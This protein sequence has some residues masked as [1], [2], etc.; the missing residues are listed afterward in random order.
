MKH[1]LKQQLVQKKEMFYAGITP[2]LVHMMHVQQ[3]QLVPLIKFYVQM[4][5]VKKVD[6][7]LNQKI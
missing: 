7:V 4:E 1:V 3:E 2:V 6:I 5:V